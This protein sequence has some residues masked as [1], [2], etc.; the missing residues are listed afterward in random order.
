MP[1]FTALIYA[2]SEDAPDLARCLST[3]RVANDVLLINADG[4][5]EI[6]RLAR[7]RY[8]RILNGIP[9]VTPGAYL[10][11]SFHHWLLAIRPFEALSDELVRSLQEWKHRKQDESAGYAFGVLELH[12]RAW[13]ARG[14]ELRLVNRRVINWTGELPP[15]TS[16]PLLPGTLLRYKPLPVAEKLAS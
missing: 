11:D 6:R 7:S 8:V 12:D 15:N 13:S 10:M 1:K 14:P 3:L 2:R 5:E 4:S 16:A 9:G